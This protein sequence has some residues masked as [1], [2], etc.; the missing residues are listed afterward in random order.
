MR[1]WIVCVLLLFGIM[2]L[3]CCQA[4]LVDTETDELMIEALDTIQNGKK[5]SFFALYW[6]DVLPMGDSQRTDLFKQ[7]R[8]Y[9][10][11]EVVSWKKTSQNRSKDLTTQA[12]MITCVYQVITDNDEYRVQAVR[13]VSD[14]KSLLY[15]LN[16]AR[17]EE[18]LAAT[19]PK[20]YLKDISDFSGLQWGL[21]IENVL[22]YAIIILTIVRCALDKI[23]IK[24]L[25]IIMVLLQMMLTLTVSNGINFNFMVTPLGFA[26]HLIYPTGETVSSIML[27]VGAIIYW[28]IRKNLIRKK[29]EKPP[30]EEVR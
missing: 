6:D 23:K 21:L 3:S 9:Y 16:I 5:E 30:V 22:A 27:P 12:E 4:L 29:A 8:E 17:N 19:V 11:G 13:K 24:A 14:E 2:L 15:A 20:G 1:K 25:Y 10:I 28:S 7:M 26:Q 18:Y